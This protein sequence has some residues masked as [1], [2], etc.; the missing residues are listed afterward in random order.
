[1]FPKIPERSPILDR[2]DRN[3]FHLWSQLGHTNVRI[4]FPMLITAIQVSFKNKYRKQ[5]AEGYSDD[6]DKGLKC[7]YY[8]DGGQMSHGHCI[9]CP[10]W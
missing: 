10:V 3:F 9:K 8:A 7:S 4:I 5:K 1:M 2:Q 6:T